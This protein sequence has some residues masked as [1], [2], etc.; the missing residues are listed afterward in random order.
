MKRKKKEKK[1]KWFYTRRNNGE[2]ARDS[3]PSFRGQGFHAG[4]KFNW[5]V[6]D[7]KEA[8]RQSFIMCAHLKRSVFC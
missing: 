2:S 5:S 6:I 8:V 4:V 3:L 7:A 1:K